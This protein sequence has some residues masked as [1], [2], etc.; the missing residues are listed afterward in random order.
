MEKEP[1]EAIFQQD[2]DAIFVS[3]VFLLLYAAIR[4]S[5]LELDFVVE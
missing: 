5:P 4:K 3:S 2:A 1:E